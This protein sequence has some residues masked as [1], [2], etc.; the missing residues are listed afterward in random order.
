[1]CKKHLSLRMVC[2]YVNWVVELISLSHSQCHH[3]MILHRLASVKT[4]PLSESRPCNGCTIA[5][6]ASA[7][8]TEIQ[9]HK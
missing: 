3:S 9:F 4:Y 8:L 6:S 5:L 1:M 2:S 7:C